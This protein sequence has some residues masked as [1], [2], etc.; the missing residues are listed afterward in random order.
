MAET[1]TRPTT[2][3]ST[4]IRP[5][6][7]E[8]KWTLD[9]IVASV[10][11]PQHQKIRLLQLAQNEYGFLRDEH[12]RYLADSIGTSYTDLY[13]IA[14]FYAQFNLNP[15]GRHHISVCVGTGCH[16]KGSKGLMQKLRETLGIKEDETTKDHRF[17]MKSV[18]CLGCCG[19]APLIMIDKET[20]GRVKP[21]HL[22]GILE[23]FE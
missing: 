18:R 22:E 4:A 10:E 21:T 6:V 14:T 16:V 5:L 7:W 9:K 3:R 2:T 17:S 1:A 19:L 12:M 23:K 8:E 13:G 20:F 11:D 15:P